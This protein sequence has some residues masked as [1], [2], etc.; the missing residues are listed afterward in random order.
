MIITNADKHTQVTLKRYLIENLV[1][2]LAVLL[3]HGVRHGIRSNE[4]CV[5]IVS[6][7]HSTVRFVIHYSMTYILKICIVVVSSKKSL[8]TA[9]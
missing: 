2:R 9:P 5:P 1:F 8:Y 7:E 6:T 3:G 4:Q